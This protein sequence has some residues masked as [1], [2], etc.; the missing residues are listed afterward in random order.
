[1]QPSRRMAMTFIKLSKPCRCP[2]YVTQGT[3]DENQQLVVRGICGMK[4][5]DFADCDFQLSFQENSYKECPRILHHEQSLSKHVLIPKNDIEYM[6]EKNF[7]D[8]EYI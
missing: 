1:M 3:V 5:A 2:F 4:S 7:S 6:A 8:I